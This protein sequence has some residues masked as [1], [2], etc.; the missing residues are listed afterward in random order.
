MKDG[1]HLFLIC[2]FTQIIVTQLHT[3]ECKGHPSCIKTTPRPPHEASHFRKKVLIKSGTTNTRVVHM[4]SFKFEKDHSMPSFHTKVFFL[5][6]Y[7]RE[8]ANFP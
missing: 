1:H 4:A 2:G 8:E 5:R 6:K 3:G 7:V